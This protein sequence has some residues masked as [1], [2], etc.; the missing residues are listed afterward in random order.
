[1]AAD[2]RNQNADLDI[3]EGRAA[4][5][6]GRPRASAAAKFRHALQ[7]RPE[8]SEA[9]ARTWTTL[10]PCGTPK[11]RT[12]SRRHDATTPRRL[13]ELEGY[14]REGRFTE[15]EPLLAAYVKDGRVLLGLVRARLQ[16]VRAAEDRRVHQALAKSLELDI[17]NAEA[18]KILG[19]T[20]MIIGRFDAAQ[21]EFEQGIRY[22]PDSAELHYNL[23]KLFSIQDNWEPARKAFEAALRI[24]PSYVEALDALGFAL[25]A[26]GDDAGAVANVREGDRAERRAAGKLRLAPT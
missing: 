23:G 13:A 14:I 25:E 17:R 1:M 18:H 16:P 24:D 7:L 4:L 19:R 8:S 20:L 26:L 11:L 5:E 9:Q 21:I 6:R 2:E 22:K 10:P 12:R 15:V 3:A